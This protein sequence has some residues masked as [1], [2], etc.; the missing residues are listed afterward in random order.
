[1]PHKANIIQI[2]RRANSP[3]AMYERDQQ[4]KAMAAASG[5]ASRKAK[6]APEALPARRKRPAAPAHLPEVR[7]VFAENARLHADLA[8]ARNQLKV[9]EMRFGA[10]S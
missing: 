10:A 2:P 1:M 8:I 4:A 6:P 7:A 5:V 3:R 9:Y